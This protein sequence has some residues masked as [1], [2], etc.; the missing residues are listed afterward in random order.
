MQH[1]QETRGGGSPTF[2]RGCLSDLPPVIA[3]RPIPHSL[4]PIPFLFTLLRTLLRFFA[5]VK[6]STLLF[7]ISSALFAKNTRGWGRGHDAIP[8]R[9]S[10]PPD[11]RLALLGSERPTQS[12]FLSSLPPYFLTSLLLPVTSHGFSSPVPNCTDGY[13]LQR[14]Y[15]PCAIL[16]FLR[17]GDRP[18]LPPWR[19]S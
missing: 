11:P 8:S 5:L 13:T 12:L 15:T 3:F 4:P 14:V 17:S 2:Q 1:L 6:N 18:F 16:P 9:N 10:N 19:P 7:S